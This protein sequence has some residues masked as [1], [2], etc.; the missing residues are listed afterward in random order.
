MEI[1]LNGICLFFDELDLFVNG[2]QIGF[3]FEFLF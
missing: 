3:F 2:I 1:G